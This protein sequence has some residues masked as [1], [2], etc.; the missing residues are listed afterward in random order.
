MIGS[1][2]DDAEEHEDL[3]DDKSLAWEQEFPDLGVVGQGQ[4]ADV[5]HGHVEGWKLARQKRVRWAG[6]DMIVDMY[7]DREGDA[8]ESLRV[9]VEKAAQR[10]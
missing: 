2:D 6:A 9:M 3:A 5:A 4:S 8:G 7:L 1:D 10:K